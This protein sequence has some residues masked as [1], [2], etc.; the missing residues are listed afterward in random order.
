MSKGPSKFTAAE[1]AKVGVAIVNVDTNQLKC[2]VCGTGWS[3]DIQPGG[4]QPPNYWK[5][6]NGCNAKGRDDE[7]WLYARCDCD[8]Q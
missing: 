4:H 6:P 3:P 5:C 7:G 1:L 2:K 8:K